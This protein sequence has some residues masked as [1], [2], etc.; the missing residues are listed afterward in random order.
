TELRGP[1]GPREPR[2]YS[3]RRIASRSDGPPDPESVAAAAA[4]PSGVQ[5]PRGQRLLLPP[6]LGP[7]LGGGPLGCRR[8]VPVIPRGFGACR[9]RRLA[10][11][12]AT[13]AFA[14]HPLPEPGQFGR[15]PD[16]QLPPPPLPGQRHGRMEKLAWAEG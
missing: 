8:L 14:R 6:P 9:G 15:H 1:A 12:H 4:L 16:L 7:L 3:E 10:F 2:F 13:A 5:E 11:H